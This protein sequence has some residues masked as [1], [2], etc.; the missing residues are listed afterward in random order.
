MHHWR[1]HR[2]ERRF[3]SVFLM[4]NVVKDHF[5]GVG[6]HGGIVATRAQASRRRAES[7]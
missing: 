2:N 6:T 1:A 3:A 7:P 4:Q 5:T